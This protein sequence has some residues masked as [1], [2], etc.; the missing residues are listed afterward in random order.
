MKKSIFNIIIK[1]T[2]FLFVFLIVAVAMVGLN[3]NTSSNELIASAGSW[4]TGSGTWP[5]TI[6][7]NGLY[8]LNSYCNSAWYLYMSDGGSGDNASNGSEVKIDQ[9]SS[10][11]D[12]NGYHQITI[13]FG[14]NL[15][16]AA[17]NSQFVYTFT[18]NLVGG[19]PDYT[20]VFLR[21]I[22]YNGSTVVN[23]T[24]NVNTGI[25]SSY[26][27]R[28]ISIT[29]SAAVYNKILLRI[30][31]NKWSGFLNFR[32]MDLFANSMRLQIT[33]QEY[34]VAYNTQGG[35]GGSANLTAT[36]GLPMPA[37]SAPTRTG[38][39]FGGYYSAINGGGTQY[40]T[41]A[42][43]S[44][45]TYNIAGATTLYAK[46]TANTYLIT[47]DQQGGSGGTGSA[48]ATYDSN[49]PAATAPTRAGYTF[50]GYWTAVGGSGTQY[51]ADNMA[52]LRIWQLL[53][54]TT[55]YAKWI[56]Q[57]YFVGYLSYGAGGL[58]G[59]GATHVF[60]INQGTLYGTTADAIAGNA[61]CP[62][63]Y[64]SATTGTTADL[65]T[66]V[67]NITTLLGSAPT[68]NL[69]TV[70][71]IPY[72]NG[73]FTPGATSSAPGTISPVSLAD[74]L[75]P[76]I[77]PNPSGT[78]AT[79][80][81]LN[82]TYNAPSPETA[83]NADSGSTVV[84]SSFEAK[85]PVDAYRFKDPT[86]LP[87]GSAL[88]NVVPYTYETTWKVSHTQRRWYVSTSGTLMNVDGNNGMIT[89]DGGWAND[90]DEMVL[91][92]ET[93]GQDLHILLRDSY[94]INFFNDDDSII[95]VRGG[96]RVFMYLMGNNQIRMDDSE[97]IGN[98]AKED[99]TTG[100]R[101]VSLF[102]IGIGGSNYLYYRR[103]NVRA[104]IYMPSGRSASLR[105]GANT[106]E[107]SYDGGFTEEMYSIVTDNLICNNGGSGS[108]TFYNSPGLPANITFMGV[109]HSL[110]YY[111]E[112]P[113]T[114]NE[115][116]NWTNVGTIY[117]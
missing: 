5:N 94:I 17:A 39:T 47:F 30:Y 62:T 95:D 74:L 70:T 26:A 56:K 69:V 25:G 19:N 40:Y 116:F 18:A 108:S 35:S 73:D 42:M 109:S 83:V 104:C 4:S 76:A 96:G 16:Y 54:N 31:V 80:S 53:S 37:N 58:S 15:Q 21:M 34:N 100:Q 12:R 106:V 20:D 115:N 6:D 84:L 92:F 45:R 52:S 22:L 71:A 1:V 51:Y 107:Y 61:W 114:A 28:S 79:V 48:T 77:T 78:V 49:M 97:A 87:G 7:S 90:D 2:T 63:M 24:G 38:Y 32:D 65:D 60:S 117:N 3:I 88:N 55:L 98:E 89:G 41:P 93:N 64:Y 72:A 46:W 14:S 11:G 101:Q 91:V 66:I 111:L 102:I 10:T 113:E 43:A 67:I 86:T 57:D 23:D 75:A 110:S 8:W 105:P 59:S 36:Y 103:T 68:M 13:N 27:D 9:G 112:T 29:R 82:S 44:A 85:E 99:D 50:K 33:G 81:T